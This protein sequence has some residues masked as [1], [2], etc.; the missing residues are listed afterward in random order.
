M[1]LREIDILLSQMKGLMDQGR[2][3][4]AIQ[5]GQT[6]LTLVKTSNPGY[7][8]AVHYNLGTS[9]NE[10]GRYAEAEKAYAETLRE[11]PNDANTWH[12]RAHN[13][14]HWVTRGGA[15]RSYLVT[16]LQYARK[17]QEINPT[18]S[19]ISRL[20]VSIQRAM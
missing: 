20:I 19:D 4:D 17:A 9:Y 12:N 7:R 3:A 13:Y 5:I 8:A 15:E 1:P 11:F 6:L 18:D 14:L 16:A 10:L 2:F